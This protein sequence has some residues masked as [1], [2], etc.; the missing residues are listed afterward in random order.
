M[1][2]TD[3]EMAKPVKDGE[4]YINYKGLELFPTYM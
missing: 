1:D 3:E 4:Y 2:K